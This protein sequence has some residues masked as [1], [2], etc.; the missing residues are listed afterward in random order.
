MRCL[1]KRGAHAIALL[2]FSEDK[3]RIKYVFDVKDVQPMTNGALPKLWDM[4]D[5]Y[6]SEII[7]CLK[8]YYNISES[9]SF[10]ENICTLTEQLVKDQKQELR[11]EFVQLQSI[12]QLEK[13]NLD[14][15]SETYMQLLQSSVAYCIL[16]RCGITEG[17]F[18]NR[19]NFR[20]IVQFNTMA[21]LS[22]LGNTTATI[23]KPILML[24]GQQVFELDK[25]NKKVLQMLTKWTIML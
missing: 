2:D 17:A 8:D 3:Q 6:Q 19:L 13:K 18:S 9:K 16:S 4:K 22:E 1:V 21:T 7:T 25:E 15:I 12:N 24:I 11:K 5:V 20:G 10:I 23:I 14:E